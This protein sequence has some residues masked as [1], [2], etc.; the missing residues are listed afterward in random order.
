MGFNSAF[1]IVKNPGNGHLNNLND[2]SRPQCVKKC[3]ERESEGFSIVRTHLQQQ[4]LGKILVAYI[5]RHFQLYRV[6][7]NMNIQSEVF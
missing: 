6:E 7:V 3:K 4:Y 2:P 5:N 1:K